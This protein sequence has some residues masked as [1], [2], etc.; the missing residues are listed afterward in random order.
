MVRSWEERVKGASSKVEV[1]T[2]VEQPEAV[3]FSP[4]PARLPAYPVTPGQQ[5]ATELAAT[6][7][8]AT[9]DQHHEREPRREDD[10][11]VPS[12]A[13]KPEVATTFTP[14]ST[15]VASYDVTPMPAE[16]AGIANA[17]AHAVSA[18]R[19]PVVVV[20][21][22]NSDILWASE[23]WLERFGTRDSFSRYAPTST[24][25][26][27]APLPPPGES[28]Q[29]T[30]TMLLGNGGEDLVELL[31]LGSEHD[32]AEIVTVLARDRL[33]AT[34]LVSDL[35]EVTA[36]VD[37]LI[38]DASPDSVAV[39]YIDIDRFKVIHDLVGNLEAQRLLDKVGRRIATSVREGD[40]LYRLP[41]DEFVVLAPGLQSPI[42]AS[43][44]A[45]RLRASVAGM[46]DIG[47]E[48]AVTASVGVAYNS[49][50]R[51]GE[52]LL[53]DSENAVFVAK[54]RGRNRVAV[55]DDELRSR[56]DRLLAVERQLRRAI[57][58]RQV[59]F[60]YQP[61][62]DIETGQVAGAEALL[63]LGRDIGLSAV[64]VV[65]AAEQSG[66]MG[67]LGALVVDG[68][69]EQLGDWLSAEDDRIIMVNVS[70]NQLADERLLR[71]V[72][73]LVNDPAVRPA[74]FAIEV[75]ESAI[76]SNRGAFD[77]LA[78]IARP[79]V[80]VG[81]DSFGARIST[82]EELDG[83]P[84]DYVKLH[85]S[86]TSLFVPG[87]KGSNGPPSWSNRLWRAVGPSS[88]WGS[89]RRRKRRRFWPPDAAWPKGSISR[90]Q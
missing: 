17:L 82:V 51:R 87:V 28:W 68:V 65:A 4:R 49:E 36:V 41:G 34:P 90:E 6:E 47:H 7:L 42:D 10:D 26:G 54:G 33:S 38:Q 27:E 24:D 19:M 75:P 78:S 73:A 44:L 71:T 21:R 60:A 81:I 18:A 46:S 77:R 32:G 16:A 23:A 43:E 62:I 22:H 15:W 66:L 48:M 11:A 74:R 80:K 72:A 64:E 37:G 63:R 53:S 59:K 5:A 31:L 55:H 14:S 52:L 86:L 30:R 12:V 35:G 50:G 57:D 45:E 20:G 89:S 3:S 56:S 70:A 69:R 88:P 9:D 25:Y 29:R 58:R 84:V 67:V 1:A 8:A 13:S 61:M 85:R 40:L 76:L 2:H 83:I 39:I 79:K